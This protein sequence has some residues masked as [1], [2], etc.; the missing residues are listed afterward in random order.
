MREPVD[1]L[2]DVG[3]GGLHQGGIEQRQ[4]DMALVAVEGRVVAHRL[5]PR[6]VT[7][8]QSPASSTR[9]SMP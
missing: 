3:L 1:M 8:G 4:R 7:V 2:G 5:R 9:A 6:A